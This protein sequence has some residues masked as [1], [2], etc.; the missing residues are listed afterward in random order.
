M[1]CQNTLDPLNI[2]GRCLLYLAVDFFS[3]APPLR[4][5]LRYFATLP[6]HQE[7]VSQVKAAI[8]GYQQQRCGA[9]YITFSIK[10]STSQ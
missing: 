5:P 6:E 2:F 7:R 4:E 1:I 10:S 8:R 9:I 3:L